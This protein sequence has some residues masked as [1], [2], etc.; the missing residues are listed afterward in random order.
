MIIDVVNFL[1]ENKCKVNLD[2]FQ[3]TKMSSST[4]QVGEINPKDR[5]KLAYDISNAKTEAE[6]QNITDEASKLA[7][8]K[9]HIK[10]TWDNTIVPIANIGFNETRANVSMGFVINGKVHLPSDAPSNLPKDFPSSIMRNYNV[11]HDGSLNIESMKVIMDNNVYVK[12]IQKGFSA[13][14]CGNDEYIIDFTSISPYNPS[15]NKIKAMHIADLI[16]KM[17][18]NKA[19]SKV[20]K[21]FWDKHNSVNKS[22]NIIAN[23]GEEAG[24]YLSYLGI[25]DNGFY[26]KSQKKETTSSY[27]V[28]ELLI[29]FKGMS[30]IPSYNA[31]MKKIDEGKNLNKADM[32]V[33]NAYDT[34]CQ[35][36]STMNVKDFNDWLKKEIDNVEKD[37]K[38]INKEL[39][40]MKMNILV[41]NEWFEE[42]T[43][44]AGCSIDYNGIN[45]EFV[46]NPTTVYI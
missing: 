30:S 36:E 35:N 39:A 12:F 13:V 33:K 19:K 21:V 10:F 34:C 16:Y 27:I 11:I 32:L 1:V 28:K 43:S 26:P 7:Y 25:T 18:G 2:S 31:V 8:E 17:M 20:Y 24:E 5:I 4:E 46:E 44:R 15:T 37:I 9:S 3:Y 22:A 6:I 42:F 23:Y 38:V 41:G 45:V 29:K 14:S 40:K